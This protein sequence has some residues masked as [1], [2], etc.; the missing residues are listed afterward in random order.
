MKGLLT[1]KDR[2]RLRKLHRRT[3]ERRQADRIKT[4]LLLDDGWS[5]EEIAEVLL[6]DDETVR[7]WEKRYRESGL[8]ALL[9]DQY[10]GSEGKL[11]D[12]DENSLKAHLEERVYQT[13][14]EVIGHIEDSYGVTYSITGCQKLMHRLGFVYKK[15]RRIPSNADEERQL[16][17]VK[18]Y[19]KLKST[20]DAKEKVLFVDGCHPQYNS[21]PGYG[22]IAKGKEHHVPANTGRKRLN[23]NGALDPDTLQV[24]VRCD[25]TLDAFSTIAFFKDILTRYPRAPV[26]YLILDNA[27]YYRSRQVREFLDGSRIRLIFLPPYSPNLNLIERLWGFFKRNFLYNKYF[28]SFAEFQTACLDFFRNISS[29][30]RELRTLI[31]E[32]FQIISGH[33]S[34]K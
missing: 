20:K 34:A 4:V 3:T 1:L 32:N 24:T 15:A 33:L 28:P 18:Q 10:Q 13:T 7:R 23:L 6:L 21:L 25:E 9:K 22:W 11:S 26:I 29:R 17:F 12:E 19:E 5:Y 2:Q 14:S 16:A 8:E 30:R 31:T 27:P